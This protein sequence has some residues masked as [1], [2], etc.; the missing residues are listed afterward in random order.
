MP[1]LQLN[2]PPGYNNELKQQLANAVTAAVAEVTG[3]EPGTVC[4]TAEGPDPA[5]MVTDFLM[6]MERR[7]LD[8]AR[9]Y[10]ADEFVMTFPGSGELTSLEQLVEWG[11]G[12]YRFVKKTIASVDVAPRVDGP[13][14]IVHGTLSGE[15]PDGRAFSGV[16]FID[17]FEVRN[18]QLVRQ[19]VWNDLANAQPR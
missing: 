5:Q 6:T 9:N 14:V 12:R 2:L 10:L 3:T 18:N 17:R 19:D 16:R 8:H 4:I 11:K 13:L 15:W 1:M 7:E